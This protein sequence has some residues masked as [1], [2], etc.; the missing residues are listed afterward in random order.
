MR[1]SKPNT[2]ARLDLVVAL[3]HPDQPIEGRPLQV[4]RL[5]ARARRESLRERAWRAVLLLCALAP[6]A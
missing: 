2:D 3:H 4:A 1:L 5:Y 6:L